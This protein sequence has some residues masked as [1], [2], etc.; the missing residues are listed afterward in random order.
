MSEAPALIALDWGSSSFRAYLISGEGAIL[1]EIA[2]GD[3]VSTVAPGAFPAMLAR[4]VGRWLARPGL[5]VV[6]SGMVGS[7]HGWREA[8]YVSCPA[9][10][11]AIF[12]LL[13]DPQ[14]HPEIDGSG[15]VRRARGPQAAGR[16]RLGS[17]FG[18]AMRLGVPYAMENTVI[19]FEEPR[20]IAWQTTGPTALG[21]LFGGRI[22]R[23][24]LEPVEGGTRVRES[25]DITRESL[26]TRPMVRPA[27]RTT[28]RNME[29]TLERIE[30]LLGP[31]GSDAK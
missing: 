31:P 12:D 9:D 8:P 17:R 29:A 14:R 19:E 23:Y 6:A 27:A 3:G 21:R 22:W 24:E 13:A 10:P 7:R 20:R 18:M 15:T 25:W 5:P 26:V 30:K 16:L 28:A 1:D 2:T 4:L 11:Q